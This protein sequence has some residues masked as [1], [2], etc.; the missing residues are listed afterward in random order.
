MA[1]AVAAGVST[2]AAAVAQMTARA[3]VGRGIAGAA[4]ALIVAA[5]TPW[6]AVNGV[7]VG[8]EVWL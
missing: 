8:L 5:I 2:A 4:T 6:G 3:A 7:G 1:T